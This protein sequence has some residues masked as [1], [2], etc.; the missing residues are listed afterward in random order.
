M[1]PTVRKAL[2][3][4]LPEVRACAAQTFNNLYKTIGVKALNDIIPP[5]LEKLVRPSSHNYNIN[6]EVFNNINR[7]VNNIN[8]FFVGLH[9]DKTYN[10][11]CLWKHHVNLLLQSFRSVS[12][13]LHQC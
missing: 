6:T 12:P 5:L 8:K 1:I 4:P 9:G 2:C 7:K 11:F 13:D 3:D 10:T